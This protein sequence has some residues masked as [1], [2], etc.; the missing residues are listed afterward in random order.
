MIA[1]TIVV[2]LKV[3]VLDRTIVLFSNNLQAAVHLNGLE[4]IVVVPFVMEDLHLIHLF[5]LETVV[6]VLLTIALVI[7]D[8]QVQTVKYHHVLVLQQQTLQYVVEEVLVFLWTLVVVTR[9]FMEI[10]VS[11]QVFGNL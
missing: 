5:A 7:L 8:G 4:Q 10:F 11:S 9:N 2:A 6:V 1:S 3:H